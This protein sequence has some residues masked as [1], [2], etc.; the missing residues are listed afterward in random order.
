M[1]KKEKT[2][3]RLDKYISSQTKLS[4]S[5]AVKA[6]YHHKVKVNDKTASDPGMKVNT[7]TD[8]VTLNGESLSYERF[9]YY[10]LN[11]P[12][13][14]ISATED[15]E[16]KTVCDLV[17]GDIPVFPIGR[18]DIDTEGIIIL[19]ND[20]KL[21]H[22]LTSPKKHVD[23]IYYA[24][25]D[26]DI[27][28]EMIKAFEEGFDYGEEKPSLP[29]KLEGIEEKKALV[30]IHEGKFHQ[31]KRMFKAFDIEVLYLK[32]LS[33]GALSLPDDLAP[34]EY[35]KIHKEDIMLP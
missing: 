31:V 19:T 35:L 4:R 24:E 20:G 33:F 9:I 7:E 13:G 28:D 27:S 12:A 3:I 22:D 8:Q 1:A 5:D 30:T 15:K 11:K 6:I 23:K 2:I 18:L 14:V 29:G 10:L 34:G 21:A 17:P 32:R 25:L 16:Y 26:K